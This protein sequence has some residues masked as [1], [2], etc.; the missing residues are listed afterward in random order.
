MYNTK[1]SLKSKFLC[2]F[3]AKNVFPSP[4]PP[5]APRGASIKSR[6][7][8]VTVNTLAPLRATRWW[9]RKHTQVKKSLLRC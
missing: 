3:F 6:P 1:V 4:T 5:T 9:P 2:K 8:Y 7:K